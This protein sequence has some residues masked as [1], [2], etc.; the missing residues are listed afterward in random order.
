MN[1]LRRYLAFVLSALCI[2]VC[3][4]APV[5]ADPTTTVT[6]DDITTNDFGT[7]YDGYYGLGWYNFSVLNGPN[8]YEFYAG[9]NGYTN[10]VVSGDYVAYNGYGEPAAIY[11]INGNAFTLNSFEINA[12]WNDGLL[13]EIYGFDLNAN[14]IDYT[15]GVI[16]PFGPYHAQLDWTGLGEVLFVSSGGTGAFGGPA[17]HFA[18]DNVVLTLPEPSAYATFAILF[19]GAGL[20]ILRARRRKIA[21]K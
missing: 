7:V 19:G 15:Y 14:L 11:S 20:G 4:V 21:Q 9:P 3:L 5:H 2:G 12:A 17:T 18:L 6:F 8:Y 13:V 1:A 16:D 10:G